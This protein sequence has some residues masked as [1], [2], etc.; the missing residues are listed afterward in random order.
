MVPLAGVEAFVAVVRA[1][2]FVGAAAALDLSTPA[3]SRSIARLERAL[4]VRLLQRTTRRVALTD[5]GRAY[6]AH[7]DKLLE[8]FAEANEEVKAGRAAAQG[9][10]RVDVPVSL[11]RL[12]L[13]PALPPFLAA[14]SALEIQLGMNDRIVDLLEEGVDAAVR[15]G[16]LHDS[17]LVA[18]QVGQTRW[19]TAV[20]PSY[21]AARPR[22][23]HPRDLIRLEGIDFF[24]PSTGKPRA[25]EFVRGSDRHVFEPWG[26]LVVGNAE[27]T[28]DAAVQG[29]GVVQTLDFMV[30]PAVRAGKLV[31]L[32]T[33]WEALGP[34]ISVVYPS[35]RYLSGRVRAFVEFV[36]QTLARAR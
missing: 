8:G 7:C 33:A 31:R 24:Y 25:W 4:G 13:L 22:P 15:I 28:V 1:G 17:G 3:V 5:E 35:S 18:Q 36:R 26:R 16:E 2:S 19:V 12:V 21:L 14:H 9:K 34:P 27:A 20:A 6:H 30:E 10:L 11:G 23:R 29:M 32:L